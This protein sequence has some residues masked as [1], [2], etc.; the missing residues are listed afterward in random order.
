MAEPTVGELF[1]QW[2]ARR[3]EARVWEHLKVMLE[4]TMKLSDGGDDAAIIRLA[5]GRAVEKDVMIG[6]LAELDAVI[7]ELEE[8]AKSIEAQ[9]VGQ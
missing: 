8:Q 1:N 7:V 5:D 2:D 9:Q 6:V 3:K 4:R